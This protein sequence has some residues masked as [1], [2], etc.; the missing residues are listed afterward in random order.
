MLLLEK[1]C[2]WLAEKMNQLGMIGIVFVML[3]TCTDIFSRI[4]Y[5]PIIGVY[6]LVE[7]VT[8]FAVAF[9]VPYTIIVKG[10]VVVGLIVNQFPVKYQNMAESIT[11]FFSIILFGGIVWETIIGTITSKQAGEC[12]LT[13]YIPLYYL[14]G[15]I[16]FAFIVA[17]AVLIIVFVNT[18]K[19]VLNK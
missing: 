15:L 19:R 18:I 16:A 2:E 8:G 7:M 6:D 9:T 14:I 5:R 11:L 17:T 12:S 3:L 4:V 13:L 10:N 1:A